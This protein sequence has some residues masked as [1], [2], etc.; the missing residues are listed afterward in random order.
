MKHAA[1]ILAVLLPALSAALCRAADCAASGVCI[2]GVNA[3]A[4]VCLC[5]SVPAASGAGLTLPDDPAGD[6]LPPVDIPL[7]AAVTVAVP[8]APAV[9]VKTPDAPAVSAP[10]PDAPTV[11]ASAVTAPVPEAPAVTAATPEAPAVSASTP[12]APAVTAAAVTAPAASP[13]TALWRGFT[14]RLDAAGIDP[15]TRGETAE[16]N[17]GN[18]H[19]RRWL[20]VLSACAEPPAAPPAAVPPLPAF[21]A[22]AEVHYPVDWDVYRA[23]LKFYREQGCDAVLVAFG[24]SGA[25]DVPG[26]IATAREHG[27]KVLLTYS[28]PATRSVPVFGSPERL[29]RLLALHGR[30]ADAFVLHWRRT[31]LH[32]LTPPAG[33]TRFLTENVRRLNPSLPV[34]GSV[35]YGET[36]GAYPGHGWSASVPADASGAVFQGGGTPDYPPGAALAAL[37]RFTALPA[38]AV[39]L[40]DR[41]AYLHEFKNGK[42]FM[43]NFAIKRQVADGCTAA[44]FHAVIIRHGDNG[45]YTDNIGQRPAE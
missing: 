7:A 44:G 19:F 36:G 42:T 1:A 40:G 23:N 27:F 37:R 22:V 10:V 28:G 33:W 13:R 45:D 2:C 41:A 43:Q 30:Q 34:I 20:D 5:A 6:W 17:P 15:L 3:C 39:A 21:R 25:E 18:P 9:S 24:W 4:A 29:A 12:E 31:S 14:A 26:Y 38:V 16:V 8:H 11:G 35:Y 32:L